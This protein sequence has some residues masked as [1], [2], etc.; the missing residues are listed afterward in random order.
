[1]STASGKKVQDS[2]GGIRCLEKP[3]EEPR[4]DP[5]GTGLICVE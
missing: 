1:M 5:T 4:M 2:E 3:L